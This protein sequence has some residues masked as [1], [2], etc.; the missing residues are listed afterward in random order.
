MT[1]HKTMFLGVFGWL[2]IGYDL[3]LNEL[4]GKYFT[5]KWWRTTKY[6]FP[7]I[8]IWNSFCDFKCVFLCYIVHKEHCTLRFEC[9]IDFKITKPPRCDMKIEKYEKINILSWKNFTSPQSIC[10]NVSFECYKSSLHLFLVLSSNFICLFTWNFAF[11][12]HKHEFSQF[13][14]ISRNFSEKFVLILL[15]LWKEFFTSFVKFLEIFNDFWV[16]TSMMLFLP[17][18]IMG[19][20][21]SKFLAI[22]C[23]LTFY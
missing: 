21:K 14:E 16:H 19:H 17:M 22:L 2:L 6:F 1:T 23:V 10:A 11:S 15:S 3:I 7:K 4:L 9:Y 5:F 18:Y 12:R 13:C 8:W 20:E